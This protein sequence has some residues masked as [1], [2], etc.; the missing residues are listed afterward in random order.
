MER[1]ADLHLTRYRQLTIEWYTHAIN[2]LSENDF[3]CAARTDQL[4]RTTETEKK[5]RK[6]KT[7][8]KTINTFDVVFTLELYFKFI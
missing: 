1:S 2:G 5:K 3:I 7:N 8:S 4:S 6:T